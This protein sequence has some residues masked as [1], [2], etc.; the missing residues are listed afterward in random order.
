M[1]WEVVCS[2]T[3]SRKI[4]SISCNRLGWMPYRLAICRLLHKS[5]GLD[6]SENVP[7]T[8]LQKGELIAIVAKNVIETQCKAKPG[9]IHTKTAFGIR[10][11]RQSQKAWIPAIKVHTAERAM[12]EIN[13]LSLFVR[14]RIV[15]RSHTIYLRSPMVR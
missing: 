12:H 9:A 7:K 5:N 10:G 15:G 13:R 6:P 2:L 1:T 14:Y 8:F 3:R 4:P 11:N